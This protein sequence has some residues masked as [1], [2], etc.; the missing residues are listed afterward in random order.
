MKQQGFRY[1]SVCGTK[2]QRRGKT[3][4]GTQRWLCKPCSSSHTKPR[5]DVLRGNQLHGFVS[6]LLGKQSQTGMSKQRQYTSRTWRK[7]TAWCWDVIPI[8][9]RTAEIYPVVLIDGTRVGGLVCLVGRTPT[10]V[11]D[12]RWAAYEASTTWDTLLAAI[13]EPIAIVC[14]GQKGML[15]AIGRYWPHAR[16]QRCLFHVW[17]NMK[18]KLTLHPQTDAGKD[19]LRYYRTIWRVKTAAEADEW[20]AQFKVFYTAHDE[21]LKQRTVNKQPRPGQRKWW[22]THRDV[23]SAYRQIDKLLADKQLFTYTEPILQK[24]TNEPIPSTTNYVEG[25]T[26]SPL[27]DLLRSH[28]GMPQTHQQRLTEWYLYDKT[29]DKKPPRKFL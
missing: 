9:T 14:D 5:H 27:K 13:P 8:P 18:D 10:H 23:R 26:N 11:I 22:Y 17:L 4:A 7:N 29:K 19:L 3:A 16:I 15:L 24:R 28:R 20:T 1:C 6:Y 12:W 21:F 2:L 25:G